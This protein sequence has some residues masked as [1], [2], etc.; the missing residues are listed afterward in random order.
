M[1]Y[2]RRIALSV[3]A[4]SA[5]LL[6]S[7]CGGGSSSDVPSASA[8]FKDALVVGLPY[9]CKPS[10]VT[11]KTD[12]EGKL[13]CKQGEEAEFHLGAMSFGPTAV[14]ENDVITPYRIYPDNNEAAVNMA[15]LL[16]SLDDDG[17][18]DEVITID[19]TK[20]NAVTINLDPTSSTFDTDADKMLS[21]YNSSLSLVAEGDAEA[22]MNNSINDTVAPIVTL[23]GDTA[24][25]V[26]IGSPYEDAG[27][28]ANDDVHGMMTPVMSGSVN[29][30]VL[31][32]YTIT[33]TATDA[34]G[35]TG[36]ATRT[37]D[38]VNAPDTTAPVV[39]LAGSTTVHIDQDSIYTD[40]GATATDNIDGTIAPVMSGTVNTAVAGTYMITYTAEDS[41]GNIGTATRTVIV[42]EVVPVDTVAPV[43]TLIGAATVHVDQDSTYTDAG[44]T[45][46]DN[47]DGVITPVMSG[48]VNTA[49][50]G[51]YTITYTAEDTAGNI[52]TVARTVIVD[53]AASVCQNVNPITGACEDTPVVTQCQ[54]VNPITGACED[55]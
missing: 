40:A 20:L 17:I 49:V 30:A 7:A 5:A 26:I 53:A 14:R 36:R 1:T 3:C 2:N 42:D 44:A 35:N 11:G 39:T 24:V 15:Q 50:A 9:T 47:V 46:N 22:H 43:V 23:Q 38:V 18:Y 27:A 29:T 37:I 21:D 8:T 48:T 55:I 25:E 12:A 19:E 13:T 16:Q 34:A 10:G 52:G 4:A 31:G 41:A 54:N 45:A 6:L 28:K 32:R 51:T 33:W